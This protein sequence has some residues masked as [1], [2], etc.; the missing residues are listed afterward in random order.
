MTSNKT[1]VALGLLATAGLSS[2]AQAGLVSITNQLDSYMDSNNLIEGVFDINPFLQEQSGLGVD[3]DLVHATF[4][5]YGFSSELQTSTYTQ[6]VSGSSYYSPSS[7]GCYYSRWGG[8]S[9]YYSPSYYYS[10]YTY[11]EFI[12]DGEADIL[13]VDFGDQQLTD[14]T[15]NDDVFVRQYTNNNVYYYSRNYRTYNQYDRNDFG[16]I[17]AS[18]TLSV[19]SFADLLADGLFGYTG[20]ISAGHFDSLT[21]ELEIEYET[22]QALLRPANAQ[23]VSEPTALWLLPLG[24]IGIASVRR[25]KKG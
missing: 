1:K 9:C 13:L 21:F 7:G 6:Y 23:G 12:G 18:T 4:K 19:D 2:S 8:S 25:S 22:R 24:L 11:N 17:F 10:N 5:V 3:V 14:T 15:Q 20:Q 16:D